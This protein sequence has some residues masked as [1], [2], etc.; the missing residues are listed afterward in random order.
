MSRPAPH[1]VTGERADL[2]DLLRDALDV[3]RMV[4]RRGGEDLRTASDLA[5]DWRDAPDACLRGEWGARRRWAPRLAVTFGVVVSDIERAGGEAH[6]VAEFVIRSTNATRD[7]FLA[8][9]WCP[10]LH[11]RLEWVGRPS[12]YVRRVLA[13]VGR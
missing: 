1:P 9:G 2:G 10:C 12:A 4:G 13:T 5:A 11:H 6:E 7:G 3:A 8:A